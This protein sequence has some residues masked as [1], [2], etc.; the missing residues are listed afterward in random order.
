[1]SSPTPITPL[2]SRPACDP[3]TELEARFTRAIE[4]VTGSAADP[5]IRVS[6]NAKFGDF[7]VN[8][9]MGL[10]KERGANPRAIAEEILKGELTEGDVIT[11]DY[12]DDATELTLSVTKK[13]K[14]E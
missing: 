9:A 11:A 8:A 6:G 3:A 10:A 1:M 12:I 5:A 4:V 2:A 13:E 14:A 7:Q